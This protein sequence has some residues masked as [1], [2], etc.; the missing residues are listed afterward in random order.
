MANIYT[1]TSGQ[2]LKQSLCFAT[3]LFSPVRK[4][5][6]GISINYTYIF[7]IANCSKIW[8]IRCFTT[9]NPDS[10]SVTPYLPLTPRVT[11]ILLYANPKYNHDYG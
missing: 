7:F 11:K 5:F 1:Q 4:V 3:M 8:R 6:K 2:K 9:S 10:I